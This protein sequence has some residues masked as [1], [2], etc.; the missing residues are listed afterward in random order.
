MTSDITEVFIQWAISHV[1]FEFDLLVIQ[2]SW[3]LKFIS[4][5]RPESTTP[6]ITV[7]YIEITNSFKNSLWP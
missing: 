6:D 2:K 1:P 4:K 3:L 5:P 7:K